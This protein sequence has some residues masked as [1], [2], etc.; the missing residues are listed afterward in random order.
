MID[1]IDLV[2]FI[3]TMSGTLAA[4]CVPACSV[5]FFII[6]NTSD[7]EDEDRYGPVASLCAVAG[8]LFVITVLTCMVSLLLDMCNSTYYL[9]IFEFLFGCALILLIFL[10]LAGVTVSIRKRFPK[11]GKGK[12]QPIP[13]TA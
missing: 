3:L 13:A 5:I 1:P 8:I 12:N 9:I 10:G 2:K 6:T 4:L 11:M 7:K